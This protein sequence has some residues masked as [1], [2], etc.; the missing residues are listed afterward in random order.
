M[1][2]AK[3]ISRIDHELRAA[4]EEQDLLIKPV[5]LA[6]A[7]LITTVQDIKQRVEALEKDAAELRANTPR[8]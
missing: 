4:K 5:I 3:I 6:L 7:G 8:Q 1:S 2:D